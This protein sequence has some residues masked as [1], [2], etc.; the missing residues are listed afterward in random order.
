M[1]HI[2][3]MDISPAQSAIVSVPAYE[4]KITPGHI[5]ALTPTAWWAITG[6]VGIV[7]LMNRHRNGS[8]MRG[9]GT[10]GVGA[11]P[12]PYRRMMRRMELLRDLTRISVKDRPVFVGI[13]DFTH[14]IR[15]RGKEDT[16]GAGN[17]VRYLLWSNG[18]PW[19][20]YGVSR[21][22]KFVVGKGNASKDQSHA[23]M[24]ARWPALLELFGA[25]QTKAYTS[26][27]EGMIDAFAVAVI[28]WVEWHWRRGYL[29]PTILHS[30]KAREA[31]LDLLQTEPIVDD[32]RI[33]RGPTPAEKVTRLRDMV[34]Q[35]KLVADSEAEA[36][37]YELVLEQME[38]EGL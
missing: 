20:A 33:P 13:E 15:E 36:R 22:R 23:A 10:S 29:D 5:E 9:I 11:E 31:L 30:D 2:L 4:H 19:R 32:A 7:K 14:R 26:T 24:I 28:A 8:S 17:L 37:A 1:T 38:V 3:G 35:W 34:A 25:Y 16:G 21:I 18:I 6:Q 12:D 27:T